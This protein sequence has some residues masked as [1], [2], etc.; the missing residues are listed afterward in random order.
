[1]K[2]ISILL[3]A[4]MIGFLP[5]LKA[6]EGMWIPLLIK[7]NIAEMQKLGC[8]LT[9]EDIYSMNHS[10]IKDAIVIFGGGC[11]GEIVSPEGL[12]FTNHHCGF[13]SIQK[14]ST[15]ENNYLDNGFWAYAKEEEIPI[16]GLTVKFLNYME[17]VT[18]RA[19]DSVTDDLD[20]SAR[21]AKIRENSTKIEKEAS[22]DGKY[23]AVVKP[24][25]G[26][27]QYYLYVYTVY[28]D[29]RLVGTP[30]QSIGKF[31]GDTDNW[32]WPRHTGDFS[33]FRVYTA[34]D[35]SPAEYAE[36]NIPYKAKHYLPLNISPKKKDDFTMIMGN[37][38][39][40]QRYLSSW[41]VE[42]AINLYNPTI[43]KIR[44]KKLKLMKEGMDAD[45]SVKLQY[46]SK[47][48]R[49]A[50]YW[51]YFI[52][53]TKALKR[54]KVKEEKQQLEAEFENWLNQNPDKKEKYGEALPELQKAYEDGINKY[55]V[56]RIFFVEAVYRG[57]EILSYAASFSKLKDALES[58]ETKPEEIAK[59]TDALKEGVKEHFK[60]YN[61]NI[62]RNI[63][64]AMLEMYFKNVKED[65]QPVYLSEIYEKYKGD[66]KKFADHLFE[67]SIF[68]TPEKVDAFL[69]KPNAKVLKKDPALILWSKFLEDYRK[70]AKEAEPYSILKERGHRLFIA[71]LREMY[72]DKNFYPDANFTMRVTYGT[73][74]DYY[75]AD[76]VHY[77]FVTH[78]YGVMEKEDPDNPEFIVP[79]KLKEIYNTK[80]YGQYAEDGK[81]VTDFLST[82]DITGGNSGSPI[83][84]DRGQLI[85][86]AFDG[87]WE[88]MSGDIKF[89]T[90][91]QRTINVDI[92][93]LLLIMDKYA[94]AQ[95]LIDELTI[96]KDEPE[97]EEIKG[98]DGGEKADQPEEM[99]QE[100]ESEMK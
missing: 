82:N 30:P 46:A 78:L 5:R 52:G 45:P 42:S 43:V 88:A 96:I 34:P 72:P 98:V 89:D 47:Y 85:G 39:S 69:A 92:R 6:D 49:T 32:M 36:E 64:A 4:V 16:E 58:K 87:N 79:D 40:T 15:P 13:G 65:Q 93:Y 61:L 35:G 23:M 44:D 67:K 56:A 62:D 18:D 9:A 20:E 24:I 80:D 37:P 1:M 53:Q 51:K 81:L 73:V 100:Q 50:N 21:L 77:D 63:L 71:G 54:L 66:W 84:N 83:M 38:G 8:K 2:K 74:Q 48:A 11:T 33:I 26:G 17:D 3:I 91:L 28:K 19:L 41:G 86:L 59:M 27:N 25:F 68:S 70:L 94:G 75:P 60:D 22:E 57:P 55:I 90:E 99:M 97:K 7:K 10:S 76:A 95:N 31:G 12:L 14:V 29:I